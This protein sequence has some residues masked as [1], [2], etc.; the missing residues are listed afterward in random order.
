MYEIFAIFKIKTQERKRKE[1]IE[2][3]YVE[4]QL[5]TVCDSGLVAYTTM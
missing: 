5:K 4:W 1:E 2:Y 3:S